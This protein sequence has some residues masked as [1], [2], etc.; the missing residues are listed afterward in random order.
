MKLLT[1]HF[2]SSLADNSD[3]HTALLQEK[4]STSVSSPLLS[5]ALESFAQAVGPKN[6]VKS[7]EKTPTRGRGRG[8]GRGKKINTPGRGKKFLDP[9]LSV[10]GVSDSTVESMTSTSHNTGTHVEVTKLTAADPVSV[11]SNPVMTELQTMDTLSSPSK[12][13]PD[14]SLLNTGSPLP[15]SKTPVQQSVSMMKR[16]PAKD[17]RKTLEF[18]R[19]SE[20][21]AFDII[22]MDLTTMLV[23]LMAILHEK[24][25]TSQDTIARIQGVSN[26]DSLQY[27]QRTGENIVHL[28]PRT[29]NSC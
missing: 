29:V 10:G 23:N 16:I 22:S 19:A 24:M 9:P 2:H 12:V 6:G 28:A 11:W 4:G 7:D 3:F 17:V 5:Q 15:M 18:V 21:L 1:R 13:S 20:P 14:L 27:Q 8:G 26:D 25:K